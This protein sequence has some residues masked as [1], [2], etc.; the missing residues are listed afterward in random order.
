MRQKTHN[1]CIAEQ[2]IALSKLTVVAN[3]QVV[4]P[5][6]EKHA[7]MKNAKI[8]RGPTESAKLI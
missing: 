2:A 1:V 4:S 6:T 7:A 5:I 8:L 3:L